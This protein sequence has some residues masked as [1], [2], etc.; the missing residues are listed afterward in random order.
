MRSFVESFFRQAGSRIRR[1]GAISEVALSSSLH[2]AFGEER[3]VLSFGGPA[4]GAVPVEKGS[5]IIETIRR[6]LSGHGGYV[7]IRRA[8]RQRCHKAQLAR[9]IGVAGGETGSPETKPF[10][11]REHVFYIR[12]VHL[13]DRREEELVTVAVADGDNVR[14]VTDPMPPTDETDR[15][16][17]RRGVSPEELD[18]RFRLA[19]HVASECGRERA[20]E[21]SDAIHE[22]LER[23]LTRLK[24]Y[25]EGRMA[26]APSGDPARWKNATEGLD[27]ELKFKVIEELENHRQRIVVQLVGVTEVETPC[28][29]VTIPVSPGGWNYE[30][31][32]DHVD[33]RW[34]LASCPSCDT[35][36]EALSNCRGGHGICAA[37]AETCAS[38]GRT[39]CSDCGRAACGAC[40]SMVCTDCAVQC[41]NCEKATCP[42][43]VNGCVAC[44]RRACDACG[45]LCGA[46]QGQVCAEHGV[47]CVNCGNARCRSCGLSCNGCAR[48]ACE[49]C[50]RSC[51]TC[52]MVHCAECVVS[53][54]VCDK[55]ACPEHGGACATCGVGSCSKHG[56]AC[57]KCAGVFCGEHC[58]ECSQCGRASCGD[59]GSECGACAV[60]LCSAHGGRCA[61][62]G[63]SVCAEHGAECGA[64]G[65]VACPEHGFECAAC[66]DG[67]CLAHGIRCGSCGDRY[68]NRCMAAGAC[69]LCTR[70]GKSEIVRDP[71]VD[72]PEDLRTVKRWRVL[73]LPSRILVE[74]RSR[75]PVVLVYDLDGNLLRRSL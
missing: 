38:C 73:K 54:G 60:A 52:G 24:T 18:R 28:T 22:R 35:P 33:G 23:T 2:E 47:T 30:A 46:C 21:L 41:E 11:R 15:V 5:H 68:C 20:E 44:D 72:V 32:W 6:L 65:A 62:C 49:E 57:S 39:S 74:A 43:H 10:L 45:S 70:L 66:G 53:C 14:V 55:D 37:C 13:S 8:S 25:Y 16:L 61:M 48:V 17:A 1:R 27:D 9:R 71:G 36:M 67:G 26:E 56:G 34:M 50:S 31:D 59:C 58:R 63:T 19:A 29:R 51:G 75:P 4:P 40:G 7:R 64:C 42:S 3:L 12:L 69:A